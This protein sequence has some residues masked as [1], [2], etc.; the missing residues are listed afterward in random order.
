MT[1]LVVPRQ[2]CARSCGKAASRR[3][4]RGPVRPMALLNPM[5]PLRCLTGL[6]L[7]LGLSSAVSAAEQVQV[8]YGLTLAGLRRSGSAVIATSTRSNRPTSVSMSAASNTS[9]S[10]STRRRSSLSGIAWTASG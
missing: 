2:E 6:T 5:S 9:V 8:N 4:D 7:A 1:G 10:N 3:I